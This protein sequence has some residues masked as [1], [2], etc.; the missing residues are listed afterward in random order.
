MEF[1]VK[2][3]KIVWFFPKLE[4]WNY[5]IRKKKTIRSLEQNRLYWGYIIKYIALAYKEAWYSH[6]KDYIHDLFK[7]CF[8]PKDRIYSD[9]SKKYILKS[10]STTN[11]WV[12]QFKEF[13]DHI[14]IICEF[15]NLWEIKWLE[16]LEPFVIPDIN[17]E[18]LLE[19]IDK[20]I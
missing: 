5:S 3:W 4:D 18:D 8:L 17:E 12:K 19:W 10:W 9:F 14:K 2:N 13:I 11:L 1:T 20:V 7:R 15:W 16:P 6:T